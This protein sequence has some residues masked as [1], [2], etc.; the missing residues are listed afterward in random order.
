MAFR[1]HTLLPLD[2]CLYALQA[3]SR[4]LTRSSLHR[5]F[6]RHGVSRLPNAEGTRVRREFNAYPI[7]YIHIDLAEVWTDEGKLYLFVAIDRVSKF[8]FAELHE[9]ATRTDR[10]GLPAPADRA[11]P[12]PHPHGAYRQRLS[13]HA[14]SWRLDRRRDST[15]AG[16]SSALSAP[17]PLTSRAPS[18][19]STIASRNSN[20]RG[21]MAKSN[22]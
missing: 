6:Q 4:T 10:G 17:T 20:I 7:G 11:C 9:R 21:P 15:D 5:L 14:A 16:R 2:D 1:R 19:A 18:T 22:G 8:A 3:T 13:V 12:V